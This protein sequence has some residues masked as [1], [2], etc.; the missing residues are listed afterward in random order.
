M[1]RFYAALGAIAC[2]LMLIFATKDSRSE[3]TAFGSVTGAVASA[4]S[5]YGLRNA[6]VSVL[7]LQIGT[8]TNNEGIFRFDDVPQGRHTIRVRS[9]GFKVLERDLTVAAGENSLGTIA[10]ESDPTQ[11]VETRTANRAILRTRNGIVGSKA[12]VSAQDIQMLVRVIGREPTVGDRLAID[13]RIYNLGKR[14]TVMPLCLDG[15][16]G[17]RFPRVQV[18]VEGPPGGFVVKPYSRIGPLTELRARDLVTVKGLSSLNPFGLAWMPANIRLGRIMKPGK[19]RVILEYSTNEPDANRW[20]GD[21]GGR[22]YA[23]NMEHLYDRLKLLPLV[24]LA[25]S[26]S[27]IVRW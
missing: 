15:S 26:V 6:T 8:H 22:D 17:A 27:F 12:T 24:E 3:E 16:D 18:R 20:L 2:L 11:T 5:G 13:A 10:L 21:I 4:D 23:K 1:A 25:D 14:E 9:A 19:Y 7:D